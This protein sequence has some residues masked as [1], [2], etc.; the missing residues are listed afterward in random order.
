M[1]NLDILFNHIPPQRIE[2]NKKGKVCITFRQSY[3][4]FI[5]LKSF[6]ANIKYLC[7][8]PRN[9]LTLNIDMDI[10]AFVDG[11]TVFLFSFA[12]CYLIIKKPNTK[13]YFRTLNISKNNITTNIIDHSPIGRFLK[14][15]ITTTEFVNQM[16]STQANQFINNTYYLRTIIPDE[17]SKDLSKAL[18]EVKNFLREHSSDNQ[19]NNDV[20]QVIS[21]L[22]GNALEHSNESCFIY[23]TIEDAELTGTL[24]KSFDYFNINILCF[25]EKTMFTDIKNKYYNGELESEV[26]KQAYQFHKKAFDNHY[27]ANHFFMISAIQPYVT[28]RNNQSNGGTGLPTFI[29]KISNKVT[30]DYSYVVSETAALQFRRSLIDIKNEQIGL[31]ESSNFISELP[32]EEAISVSP[33]QIQGIL[34][35]I[36]LVKEKER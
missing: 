24:D 30:A 25:S 23:I 1:L 9:D 27:T 6:L 31:N 29:K 8:S 4:S 3:L 22:C 10:G 16:L 13:I 7:I 5:G 35:N 20:K 15:R 2:I 12:F 14:N 34:Y 17:D 26:V 36:V 32:S 21:E 11:A 28:G 33:I 19:F 18:Q